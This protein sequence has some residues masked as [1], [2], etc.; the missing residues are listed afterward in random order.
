MEQILT[1][2]HKSMVMHIF[3][4][5]FQYEF[6]KYTALVRQTDALP[7]IVSVRRQNSAL[8]DSFIIKALSPS[9]DPFRYR[10]PGLILAIIQA[11]K[12]YCVENKISC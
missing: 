9:I 7:Y 12:N 2:S 4:V 8:P 10:Y 5:P 6:S 1:T 3:E 11:I